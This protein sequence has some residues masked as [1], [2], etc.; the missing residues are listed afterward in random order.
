MKQERV[1]PMN[2]TVIISVYKDVEALKLVLDSLN[3]QTYLD[4][5]VLV[6]EDCQSHEMKT[7]LEAYKSK[8]K[9]HHISQKDDGWKKNIAL[10]NAI[11]S[12]TGDYLI[13]LDG[14]IVPYKNFVE[15]HSL[16]AEENRFLSGRRAEIGPFFTHLIRKRYLSY[17]LL[18]KLYL[19]F[20][21]FL[22]ID[23]GKHLEEGLYLG[24]DTYLEKKLNGK[25][26][27]KMMLVGCN[28]SCWKKDL[29]LINGFD[30]DYKGPSVGEDVDLAW[31]FNYFGIT[32]KSVRYIANTFHLY[33]GRSWGGA[34]EE[35]HKIMKQKK[36]AKAFRC[37]NGLVK[38]SE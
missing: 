4:S 8:I 33:H 10:N 21:L 23:R 7:F 2:I 16:M 17:R 32:Y 20:Y 35:N 37:K 29:E 6:S 13:F 28:F 11:R 38:E 19:F 14:D 31:R 15:N 3:T 9:I 5:D 24:I 12:S 34:W 36:E 18:E 1:K 26:K 30:E 27:K 22:A 25:K